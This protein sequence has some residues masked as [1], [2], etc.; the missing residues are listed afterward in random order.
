M[1]I[2]KIRTE[3]Q[4]L[5]DGQR[6]IV[7]QKFFKTGKGEYGEGDVF[8]GIRVPILRK[9]ADEY[10]NIT[11]KE[12][13]QL[14]ESSFH[15]ER[16]LA[17]LVL[18]HKYTKG[19]EHAKKNIYNLYL[20]N[21]K[22]VNNWD[23]VDVSAEH[24]IGNFLM[25]KDKAPLYILVKSNVLWERR[26]AIMSTFHY[27]KQNKFSETCKISGM[28]ISDTEILVHKAVGWMLRKVGKRSLQIEKKFLKE[29]YK[30]MPRT[31]LRYAIERFP[32]S[33]R[34]KYLRG[35]I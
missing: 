16:M 29:H 8:L 5:G 15:E 19:N 31:M 33:E 32:G 11:I 23:L 18:I 13:K 22:F 17:L 24:I 14:L 21:T 34:Q 1:D 3:L 30:T 4:Q 26:I 12:T 20:K 35:K 6:A 28:L 7:L 25:D 2:N 27:I 9:M 10:Q